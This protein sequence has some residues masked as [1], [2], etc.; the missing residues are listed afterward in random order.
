MAD[1]EASVLARLK[2]KEAEKNAWSCSWRYDRR[3][4]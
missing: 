2:N 4:Q 1:M 3:S